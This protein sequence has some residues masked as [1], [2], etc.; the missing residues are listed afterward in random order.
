M[1]EYICQASVFDIRMDETLV[2]S[3]VNPIRRVL[4]TDY[5]PHL[6]YI[7]P[8]CDRFRDI[9]LSPNAN[10]FLVFDPSDLCIP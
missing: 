5:V 3:W 6:T 9:P 2:I 4:D 10:Y 1:V 7:E 8:P